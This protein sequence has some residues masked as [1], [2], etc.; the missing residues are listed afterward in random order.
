MNKEDLRKRIGRRLKELRKK[1]GLTWKETA[2]LVTEKT[3]KKIS[4]CYVNKIESGNQ[5][6]SLNML[7]RLAETFS[8]P[9][10]YFI[11]ENRKIAGIAR[12][13]EELNLLKNSRKL[14]PQE[15]KVVEQLI[16]RLGE[17]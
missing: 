4:Y 17:K 11:G 8:V 16:K 2:K 1:R 6:P 5:Y 3:G 9:I 10:D 7:E 15:K 13:E 12:T 14:N